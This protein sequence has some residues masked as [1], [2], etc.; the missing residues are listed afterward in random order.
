MQV[1]HELQDMTYLEWTKTRHSSGTAGSFLKAYENKRGIKYYYKLSSYDVVRGIVGHEC[2]NEI[3]ADRLLNA[4]NID[5]LSYDLVHAK[6]SIRGEKC[7]TYLCRSRD[8][9]KRGE[10]KIALDAFYEMEALPQETPLS[11]AVRMGFADD[12]YRMLIL[13]FI[14]LNR[15]R[16]G[17]NIEVLKDRESRTYRLAPLFDHG[18][19][20]LFSCRNDS[21]FAAKNPADDSRVQCFFGS[22][23]SY[24][25]LKLIPSD[26]LICLP[27]FNEKLEKQLFVDLEDVLSGIQIKS[28]WNFIKTRAG[29]YEDF[30]NHRSCH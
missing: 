16:H 12:V 19:S 5:H 28:L 9:K 4:M 20:L 3:I 6:I 21:D 27:E 1:I 14:I 10:S 2:I 29:I 22:T 26:K 18:V 15:D 11:F 8:F 25:N 30:C 13:D 7:E 17:A 24:E 23:S